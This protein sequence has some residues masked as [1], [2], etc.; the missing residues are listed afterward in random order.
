M[1][2]IVL[3]PP[4]LRGG[5]SATARD[6]VLRAANAPGWKNPPPTPRWSG[7]YG[8]PSAASHLHC[9]PRASRVTRP[10]G[11]M[12]HRN[13][14]VMATFSSSTDPR[15]VNPPAVVVSHDGR[16][17][18]PARNAEPRRASRIAPPHAPTACARVRVCATGAGGEGV[19]DAGVVAAFGRAGGSGSSPLN[20]SRKNTPKTVHRTAAS[21]LVN[22]KPLPCAPPAG[23]AVE[24][25]AT[26]VGDHGARQRNPTA[27]ETSASVAAEPRRLPRRRSARPRR[28][29]PAA[30]QAG[31]RDRRRLA[32][33]RSAPSSPSMLRSSR[34][35]PSPRS[36]SRT[37]T[38]CVRM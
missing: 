2:L 12:S 28:H 6:R 9:M 14:A 18:L 1:E 29:T 35:A 26:S 3:W 30:R 15:H 7:R 19:C 16:A 21:L 38:G 36:A 34:P 25:A 17:T 33:W 24:N 11:L 22:V 27:R 10:D 4:R 5:R 37:S 13:V 20:S 32:P 8:A 23:R 31:R